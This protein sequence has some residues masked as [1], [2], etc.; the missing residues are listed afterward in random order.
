MMLMSGCSL[1]AL[2]LSRLKISANFQQILTDFDNFRGGLKKFS[3]PRIP[4][5]HVLYIY[6]L[7]IIVF[8]S[9]SFRKKSAK[10]VKF[11]EFR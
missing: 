8:S 7:L 3:K 9:K 10:K 1:Q 2:S 11:H 6:F 5:I 4:L